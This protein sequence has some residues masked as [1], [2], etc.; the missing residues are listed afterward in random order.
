MHHLQIG[1]EP[2]AKVQ[3]STA[4][5]FIAQWVSS[6]AETPSAMLITSHNATTQS[7]IAASYASSVQGMGNAQRPYPECPGIE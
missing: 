7:Q 5:L 6:A 4:D 2:G 3:G 1:G